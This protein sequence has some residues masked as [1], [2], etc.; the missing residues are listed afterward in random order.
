MKQ[1]CFRVH[2]RDAEEGQRHLDHHQH[3]THENARGKHLAVIRLGMK[4][5]METN[6]RLGIVLKKN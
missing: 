5:V 1:H 6:L 2:T 3:Q 4:E